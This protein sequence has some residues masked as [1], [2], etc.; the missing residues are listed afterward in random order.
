MFNC[1][2]LLFVNPPQTILANFLFYL[3][4]WQM[5]AVFEK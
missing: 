3:P 1:I 2:F 4:Y 5:G